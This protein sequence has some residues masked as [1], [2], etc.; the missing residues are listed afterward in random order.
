MALVERAEAPLGVVYATDAAITDKVRVVGVFPADSHPKI[1]YPVAAVQGAKSK[2]A[3][4][5]IKF[6]SAPPAKAL[7]T[8]YGFEVK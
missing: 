5:F 3:L 6:M 8:K 7:W 2:A 1:D 4:D